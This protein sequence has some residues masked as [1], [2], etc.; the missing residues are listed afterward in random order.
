MKHDNLTSRNYK[1]EPK[2]KVECAVDWCDKFAVTKGYCDRHYRQVKNKGY[3]LD[4]RNYKTNHVEK[5]CSVNDCSN[6]SKSN[7][8]CDKHN[9]QMRRKGVILKEKVRLDKCIVECCDSSATQDNMCTKHYTQM[10]RYGKIFVRT[11]R[12]ENE[13]ITYDQ[14]SEMIIYNKD[15][16]E[17]CKTKIDT[18]KINEI[19]SIKWHIDKHGYVVGYQEGKQI[20]LH[21][22]I[23]KTDKEVKIDHKNR[24]KLDNRIEN[25]RPVNDTQNSI[26]RGM[27]SNNTSGVTG[28][29]F[30]KKSGKWVARIGINRKQIILGLFSDFNEAV[31][32][33][34][35][36]EKIYHGEYSPNFKED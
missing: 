24:D 3:I 9:T 28:V 32:I 26:N 33:R 1:K 30:D 22:L 4:N 29:G 5:E 36:A 18:D 31:K 8:Y 13:I 19:K 17:I 6:I 10:H 23:T 21:K 12:D 20:K 34:K 15:G 16:S 25:L 27:Q 14:Y 35:E 11:N 2:E 7:G